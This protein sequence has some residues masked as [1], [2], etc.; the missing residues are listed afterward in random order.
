MLNCIT[1]HH[2]AGG[3]DLL[4]VFPFSRR[5]TV[6]FMT[7]E[8]D[9]LRND[10]LDAESDDGTIGVG[11]KTS[12]MSGWTFEQALLVADAI[13]EEERTIINWNPP[14]GRKTTVLM[15]DIGN[16][17]ETSYRLVAQTALVHGFDILRSRNSDT[18]K[19]L[20]DLELAMVGN[21]DTMMFDENAKYCNRFVLERHQAPVV[22]TH[23]ISDSI[24][25]MGSVICTPKIQL[26]TACIIYSLDQS[27]SISDASHKFFQQ[28]IHRF[29]YGLDMVKTISIKSIT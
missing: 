22:T 28:Y 18:I 13:S 2:R 15:K 10:L 4:P 9:D 29:E 5:C 24:G 11:D 17:T 25:E 3:S 21:Y 16:K 20:Q 23:Q 6:T 14:G 7:K 27:D 8:E 1:V 26:A 19:L 12:S